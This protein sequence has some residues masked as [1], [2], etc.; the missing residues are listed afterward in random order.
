M[1]SC[2]YCNATIL[3]GGKRQGTFRFCNVK[4]AQRG[5]LTELGSRLPAADVQRFVQQVHSGVCPKCQGAGPVDVHTSHRVWSAVYLTSW[6]SRPVV[7]CRPCGTKRRIGDL[8]FSMVLGWWG[9]PWGVLITPIQIS[10]NVAG[11]FR[12]TDP[13]VPSAALE[14]ILRLHLASKLAATQKPT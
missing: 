1:A 13:A 12:R 9:L 7:S 11:F 14:K 5:A 4:C 8:A 6:V 3:F 10:R 2:A